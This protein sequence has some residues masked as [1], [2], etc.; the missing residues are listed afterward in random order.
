[1]LTKS[2]VKHEELVDEVLRV[3]RDWAQEYDCDTTNSEAHGLLIDHE[4]VKDMAG[5][6]V[7]SLIERLN[8]KGGE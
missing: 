8:K 5:E 7:D 6:I 3:I 4:V 2:K 1:M